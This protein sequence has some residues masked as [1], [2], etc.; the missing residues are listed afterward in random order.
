MMA[1]SFGKPSSG[2]DLER[3]RILVMPVLDKC[4]LIDD[5][6]FA[7]DVMDE[8]SHLG[9]DSEHASKLRTLMQRQI[10]EAFNCRPAAMCTFQDTESSSETQVFVRASSVRPLP[11]RW[12]RPDRA[13]C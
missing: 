4:V 12:G 2:K 1:G 6:R 8:Y 3:S 10:V 11:W 9:L 7:I 5:L 13:P